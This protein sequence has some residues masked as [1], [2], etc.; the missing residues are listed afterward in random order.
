M[1]DGPVVARQ[2]CL[3]LRLNHRGLQVGAGEGADG[4]K[5]LPQR[6]HFDVHPT[7]MLS[8]EQV[9]FQE[10]GEILEFGKYVS[11]EVLPVPLCAFNGRRGAL[12]AYYHVN[13]SSIWTPGTWYPVLFL[14]A[15]DAH[16]LEFPR[17]AGGNAGA[18]NTRDQPEEVH[19]NGAMVYPLAERTQSWNA[20]LK[21]HGTGNPA[22]AVPGQSALIGTNAIH[23]SA[24]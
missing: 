3:C 1:R 2:H 22:N 19:E 21:T 18:R 13:S 15:T 23:C 5:R 6:V 16:R 17:V 20:V 12:D 14:C 7:V 8:R 9:C 11:L 24:R 4:A 10:S